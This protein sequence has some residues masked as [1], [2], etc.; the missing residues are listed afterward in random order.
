VAQMGDDLGLLCAVQKLLVSSIKGTTALPV[1]PL[2]QFNVTEARLR[3]LVYPSSASP[4]NWRKAVCSLS[5][6]LGIIIIL[7]S[8]G[9][10]SFQ[11]VMEHENTGACLLAS[12]TS[13]SRFNSSGLKER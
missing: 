6:N 10:L 1:A 8:V 3:R 11:P 9:F 7:G 12:T 13:Y 5:L 4:F 2:I